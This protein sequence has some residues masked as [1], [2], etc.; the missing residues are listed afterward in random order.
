[1]SF[2]VKTTVKALLL[3]TVITGGFASDIPDSP[4]D[5]TSLRQKLSAAA[6]NRRRNFKKYTAE[7]GMEHAQMMLASKE[8]I[9]AR[10]GDEVAAID[11]ADKSKNLKKRTHRDA[12]LEV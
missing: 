2:I 12:K 11:A 8:E 10:Y 4:S 7:T 9:E 5:D 1:M 6:Q 3:T